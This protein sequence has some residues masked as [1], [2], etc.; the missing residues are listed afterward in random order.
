MSIHRLCE[1][2]LT[3]ASFPRFGDGTQV[4]EFTYV[5]DIVAANLLASEADVPPGTIVNIAGGGEITLN[6]PHRNGGRPR[7]DPGHRRGL[8]R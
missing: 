3:G 8:S 4:R 6:E 1:A 5:A 2:V 7:R